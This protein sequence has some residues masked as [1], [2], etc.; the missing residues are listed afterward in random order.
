MTR[1]PLSRLTDALVEYRKENPAT[2][3]WTKLSPCIGALL[4]PR[5]HWLEGYG[6]EFK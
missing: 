1:R 2:L 3:W 5:D 6:V 4:V